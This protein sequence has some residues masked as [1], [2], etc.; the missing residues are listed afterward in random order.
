MTRKEEL[1][2]DLFLAMQCDDTFF[3]AH[4][5][6]LF[7][8]ADGENQMRLSAVYPEEYGLWREWHASRND[9]AFYRRYNVKV[10]LREE[11]R[12]R[13]V[14]EHLESREKKESS[15]VKVLL[16]EET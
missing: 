12:A 15:E 4:L 8:K 10:N 14:Y 9:F 11:S 16:E 13:R 6:R 3:R 1:A 5:Y 2:R 7:N